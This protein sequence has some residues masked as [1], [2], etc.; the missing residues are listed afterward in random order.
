M[1][2]EPPTK[3]MRGPNHGRIFGGLFSGVLMVVFGFGLRAAEF[4]ESKLPPPAARQIDFWQRAWQEMAPGSPATLAHGYTYGRSPGKSGSTCGSWV[5]RPL[6][7]ELVPAA[8]RKLPKSL[9]SPA[10]S[11]ALWIASLRK[12]ASAKTGSDFTFTAKY[13]AVDLLLLNSK[14][15]IVRP[16]GRFGYHPKMG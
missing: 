4:D 14:E 1:R 10:A 6:V 8:V 5:V 7:L 9:W 12:A 15:F 11:K 13:R 2:E 3:Q 16:G